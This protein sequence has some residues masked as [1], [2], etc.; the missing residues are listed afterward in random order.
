MGVI[1]NNPHHLAG[2]ID[3][4]GA[5]KGAR[6][7]QLCDAFDIPLLSLMD[8]PGIMVGPEVEQTALV[9]HSTRMFNTGAN[10]SAIQRRRW[11]TSPMGRAATVH[12]YRKGHYLGSGQAD[13]VL[14]EAGLD[15]QSQYQAILKYVKQRNNANTEAM[16]V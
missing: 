7:L 10:L 13:K 14:Q 4:D 9:R 6:F 12:P 11:I 5:D 1:A 2:A 16:P 15:G 8:C 3:S